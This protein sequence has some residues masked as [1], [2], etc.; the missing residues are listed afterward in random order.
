[1]LDD[2]LRP[3]LEHVEEAG[4]AIG[5]VEF[6]VLLDSN[7]REHP[8]LRAQSIAGFGHGFFFG[9]QGDASRVPLVVGGDLGKCD[10]TTLV[11]NEIRPFAPHPLA[12][13]CPNQAIIA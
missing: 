2:E 6:V 5:S 10:A 13:C 4:R 7:H 8:S 3:A 9:E 12:R 1:M 11:S